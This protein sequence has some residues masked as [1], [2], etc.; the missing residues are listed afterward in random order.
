[1]SYDLIKNFKQ[2]RLAGS[3]ENISLI[4]SKMEEQGEGVNGLTPVEESQMSFGVPIVSDDNPDLGHLLQFPI[5]GTKDQII[6]LG[7]IHLH[8]NINIHFED[9]TET[10]FTVTGSIS[11]LSTDSYEFGVRQDEIYTEDGYTLL[12]T[13]Y[14]YS[15]EVPQGKR[16]T[17]ASTAEFIWKSDD[18]PINKLQT[19]INGVEYIVPTFEYIDSV[20]K[21][22]PSV[23]QITDLQRRVNLLEHPES[24]PTDPI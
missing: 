19:T 7:N 10:T 22:L 9:E 4:V 17:S 14:Y 23:E 20:V 24:P 5:V 21:T 15:E 13:I 16:F 1:M 18:F 12:I 3:R 6:S 11:N 8:I 2:G